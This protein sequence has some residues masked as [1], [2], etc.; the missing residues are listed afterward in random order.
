MK[1]SIDDYPFGSRQSDVPIFGV[2]EIDAD[3]L[4][5]QNHYRALLRALRDGKGVTAFGLSFYSFL[6]RLRQHFE[7]EE[8]LMKRINFPDRKAHKA[9]HDKL[10]ADAEDF[11][12]SVLSRFEKYDC[13]AVAKYFGY[14]LLDHVD[15]YDRALAL[16][17]QQAEHEERAAVV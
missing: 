11:L 5:L 10:M 9:E 14:W 16:S 4:D 13:S 2:R 12:S 1:L 17:L 7:S 8:V 3:H 6:R 15:H